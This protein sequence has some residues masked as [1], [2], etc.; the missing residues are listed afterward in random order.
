MNIKEDSNKIKDAS[1][2]TEVTEATKAIDT[3]EED[4]VKPDTI[5]SSSSYATESSR[6]KASPL[7]KKLANE[8]GIELKNLKGTGPNGRIIKNDILTATTTK[9][10]D[11]A[12]LSSGFVDLQLSNMRKVI[13][14]RL[15]H[16]KQ[17]IPHYYLNMEIK[18]DRILDLR[19]KFNSNPLLQ[20]NFGSFKLSL[21]DFIVKAAA[22][23]LKQVPECNSA[24]H[25]T[26]IRQYNTV[27]IC[28]AVATPAGLITPII[29]E[30][31]KRGL[32]SISGRVKELATKAKAN[33]LKPEEYQ[34][35]PKKH[36][37]F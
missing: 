4:I 17:A 14:S 36:D 18:M 35:R 33:K 2:A 9:S 20:D 10:A 3:A 28:V 25:D 29:N 7:A 15:T 19:S 24:W 26:F 5:K 32:V 30:A 1:E 8:K 22:L 13:A 12:S 11:T 6:I 37:Y 21:N 23:A 34:V 31:D 27:D 16:S